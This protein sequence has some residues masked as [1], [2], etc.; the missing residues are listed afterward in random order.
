MATGNRAFDGKS[1]VGVLAAILEKEPEPIS[2][3]QPFAPPALDRL[4]R[5]CLTKDPDQRWQSAHDLKVQLQTISEMG[6]KP[7]SLRRLSAPAGNID[8]FS[9][10]SA[11]LAGYSLSA[12]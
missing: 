7:A 6:S 4:I 11:Q 5:N 2:S 9:A 8:S 12:R 1:Q 10:P 3:A